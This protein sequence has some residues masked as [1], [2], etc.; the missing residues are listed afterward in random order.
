M[1]TEVIPD[2]ILNF[3]GVD[4]GH[5]FPQFAAYVLDR[6][7]AFLAPHSLES[8]RVRLVLQDPLLGEL[9]RANLLEESSSFRP[10]FGR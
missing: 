2:D 3:F 4:P 9:A 8:R 10:W 6:V 1:S 5:E 7:G